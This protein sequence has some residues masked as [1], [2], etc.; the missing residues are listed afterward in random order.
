MRRL[1]SARTSLV[2]SRLRIKLIFVY[3][4]LN[5]LHTNSDDIKLVAKEWTNYYFLKYLAYNLAT[6]SYSHQSQTVT[7]ITRY[8]KLT[9]G[10]SGASIVKSG[11]SARIPL[12]PLHISSCDSKLP[13]ISDMRTE[14]S[15]RTV[16]LRSKA[17]LISTC[18]IFCLPLFAFNSF[19]DS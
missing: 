18:I 9:T 5:I 15:S 17:K 6:M 1:F 11:S 10:A 3:S 2:D 16:A 8:H 13:Y 7:N 12:K 4:I 14:E 19:S